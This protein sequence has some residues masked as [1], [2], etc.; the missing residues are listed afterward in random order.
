MIVEENVLWFEISV[1]D[2]LSMQVFQ[3]LSHFGR[4]E[5]ASVQIKAGFAT[6]V[7]NMKLKVS[8]VHNCEDQTERV[9]GFVSIGQTHNKPG[10]DFLEDLLLDQYHALS[11]SLFN[12]LLL[13]LFAGIHFAGG[14]HLTRTHLPE[15]T[16]SQDAIHSE[17][18]RSHRS[19]F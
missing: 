3:A 17:C 6:H 18:L 12:P 4:I 14:P 16:L 19:I 7:V 2:S 11:L 9:F 1:D 10:I 15:A 5:A 8:A 13:Q